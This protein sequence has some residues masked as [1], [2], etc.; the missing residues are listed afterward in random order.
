MSADN[1]IFHNSRQVW[2]FDL[3]N[4][5][6]PANTPLFPQVEK[7]IGDYVQKLLN[8][9]EDEA[10]AH[11]KTLFIKHGTT[12]NGLMAEHDVDPHDYLDFVGDIDF[13]PVTYCQKLHDAIDGLEGRKIIFTN[14]DRPY[15]DKV[16]DRLGIGHLFEGMFDIF[17]ADFIPKPKQQPYDALM[18][19]FEINPAEAVFFE[20]MARNLVPAHK[21]GVATVWINTGSPWGEAGHEADRVHSETPTLQHWLD[22]YHAART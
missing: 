15:A 1:P 2:L 14:A 5:L 21:M 3:D 10:R 13:S 20:D 16:L 18:Q 8:L 22:V 12:L 11:Q 6:Y 17:D 9:P 19:K 7:R 4:T